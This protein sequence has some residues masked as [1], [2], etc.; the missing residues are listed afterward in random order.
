MA[1]A[2]IEPESA[3]DNSARAEWYELLKQYNAV[4]AIPAGEFTDATID[5]AGALSGRLMELPAPDK[6]ALVW[7]LDYFLRVGV[8]DCTGSYIHDFVAQTVLDY[9]CYLGDAAR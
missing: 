1:K 3:R 8:D 5:L 2:P 7:K 4:E 6:A 9:H